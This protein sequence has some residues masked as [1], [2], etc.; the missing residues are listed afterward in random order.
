MAINQ[1]SN[2]A[3]EASDQA[4]YFR[5]LKEAP[6]AELMKYT[7]V[8]I[9]AAVKMRVD[10]LIADAPPKMN[11][12]VR[13]IE[14]QKNLYGFASVTVGGFKIDEFK[15]L[16]NNDGEFFVGMPSRPDNKSP[17]GYRNTV[18]VDKDHRDT[19]SAAVIGAYHTAVEQAQNRAAN[20]RPAPDKPPKIADQMA[21]AA[22]EA[23]KDNAARTTPAKDKSKNAER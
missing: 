16:A 14:P 11:I 6:I 19:F 21:K 7:G 22:E 20:L 4:E 9:D 1:N 8:N 23:A 13:P 17:G 3:L 18:F 12:T 5:I 10:A 15:I 2:A